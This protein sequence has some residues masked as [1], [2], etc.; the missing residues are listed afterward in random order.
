M[1]YGVM[2]P[3]AIAAQ[4]VDAWTRSAISSTSAF[5]NGSLAALLTQSATSGES[6]VWTATVPATANLMSLWMVYEPELVSTGNYRGLDPDVRNFI[7]PIGKMFSCFK[8]QVGD[9]ILMN[10]DCFTGSKGAN[11]FA[12]AT[13]G[14][15][16][17][18][19]GATQS[20]SCVALKYI[21]TQYISI[22]T[23]AIDDQRSVAYLMEV[24]PQT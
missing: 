10:T 4:N 16:Q 2:I 23:G 19:W 18:V 22:G 1:S 13:N 11:G 20:V 3:A 24:I 5:E 21:A 15:T 8:P 9:L 6:E 14:Q 17:F 7:N 12:N